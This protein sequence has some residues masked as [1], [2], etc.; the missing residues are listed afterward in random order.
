[1]PEAAAP[2]RPP[3]PTSELEAAGAIIVKLRGEATAQWERAEEA[4]RELAR[5][6]K[7]DAIITHHEHELL[8][9]V[10]RLRA[11]RRVA[12]ARARVGLSAKE[13]EMLPGGG[14][15][16]LAAAEDA[17]LWRRELE[18]LRLKALADNDSEMPMT[19]HRLMAQLFDLR[20]LA[21]C[22]KSGKGGAVMPDGLAE[23]LD[24][25]P[26]AGWIV[27][28][29]LEGN[30]VLTRATSHDKSM[31]PATDVLGEC[32]TYGNSLCLGTRVRGS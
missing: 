29:V 15:E 22:I 30:A 13:D 32:D 18:R 20:N 6:K 11:E 24:L 25:Q 12:A 7:R 26:A 2:P 5:L 4:L 16:A 8:A 3:V 19:E 9:E 28:R 14:E 23:L 10:E 1:M 27:A 31:R 17:P 21:D